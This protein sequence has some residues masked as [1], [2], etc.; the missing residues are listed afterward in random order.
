MSVRCEDRIGQ[1]G[2]RTGNLAPGERHKFGCTY[3]GGSV[4]LEGVP[5]TMCVIGERH[6]LTLP[7]RYRNPLT[8]RW[9]G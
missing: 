7:D 3:R 6:L 8:P 4:Q 9:G 2:W 5:N 1:I